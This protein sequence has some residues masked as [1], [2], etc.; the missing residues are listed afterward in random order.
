MHFEPFDG[1]NKR[2]YKYFTKHPGSLTPCSLILKK[3]K[4][5]NEKKAFTMKKV[6]VEF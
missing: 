4:E 6:Q 3:K 1:T 2:D 5:K